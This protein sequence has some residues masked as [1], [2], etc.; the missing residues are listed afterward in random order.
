MRDTLDQI[1]SFSEYNPT[2]LKWLFD[3]NQ[4][5]LEDENETQRNAINDFEKRKL[6]YKYFSMI[7]NRERSNFNQQI[8][9][10]KKF[11]D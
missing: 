10:R 8:N 4:E 3:E 6:D 11:Y 5:S 7:E 9:G 1:Q 2:I